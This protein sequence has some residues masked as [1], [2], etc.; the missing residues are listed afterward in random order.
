MALSLNIEQAEVPI[1]HAEQIRNCRRR[2][3]KY[4]FIHKIE[5][6]IKR[7]IDN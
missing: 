6:M 5:N 1:P 2:S 4:N 3:C 7:Y